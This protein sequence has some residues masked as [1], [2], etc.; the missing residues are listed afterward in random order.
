MQVSGPPKK[1]GVDE[2]NQPFRGDSDL[3]PNQATRHRR[4]WVTFIPG[5][6]LAFGLVALQ[7]V[8]AAGHVARVVPAASQALR[9][10]VP[11]PPDLALP[12]AVAYGDCTGATPLARTAIY[13]DTCMH[14][15]YLVAHNPGPFT[16]ILTLRT[17]ARVSYQGRLF[18]ITSVTLMTTTAQW[19]EGQRHA[20]DLTLQT[21]A[22]DALGRV[23]VFKGSAA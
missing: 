12:N 8:M 11:P 22:N 15:I 9:A 14:G 23:W 13:R 17:G 3:K 18:V 4:L 16:S 19:D 6:A 21:C 7:P 2:T 1:S 10:A 20:A 5:A